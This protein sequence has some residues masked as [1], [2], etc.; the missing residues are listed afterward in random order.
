M[1]STYVDG[2]LVKTWWKDGDVKIGYLDGSVVFRKYVPFNRQVV[3]ADLNLDD[4]C[5]FYMNFQT[6]LV[7]VRFDD[8]NSDSRDGIWSFNNNNF[9]ISVENAESSYVTF[10]QGQVDFYAWDM[11]I[12][13]INSYANMPINWTITYASGLNAIDW[14]QYPAIGN[15]WVGVVRCWH[16]AG[17][18]SR[19]TFNIT[20]SLA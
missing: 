1:P 6:A 14:I 3:V 18:A 5:Y 7:Q 19:A 15:G 10:T 11:A 16:W 2:R 4:T 9:T 13:D 20:A 8:G 12:A 17:G